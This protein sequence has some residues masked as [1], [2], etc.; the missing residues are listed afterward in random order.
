MSS[1][2]V[3]SPYQLTAEHM[4]KETLENIQ[5]IDDPVLFYSRMTQVI[6]AAIFEGIHIGLSAGESYGDAPGPAEL[7][8]AYNAGFVAG[9]KEI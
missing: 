1:N 3:H 6:Q 2:V 7:L 4:A 5:A 8:T 9:Q